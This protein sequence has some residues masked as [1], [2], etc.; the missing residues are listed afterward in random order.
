MNTTQI[1]KVFEKNKRFLG[2]FP[3]DRV[4]SLK[5]FSTEKGLI[6]NL[7]PASKPGSHWVA[8]FITPRGKGKK[9]LVEY[10]DS[11][12]FPPMVNLPRSKQQNYR[13]VFNKC[14]LQ[15]YNTTTCGQFCVYFVS[16]R[17]K[18]KS[19]AWIVSKL[20]GQPNPDAFVRKYVRDSFPHINSQVCRRVSQ[21]CRDFC[22]LP[23]CR[24]INL[25]TL[26]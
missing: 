6:V 11:Y 18:N 14:R 15:G 16:Q 3:S 12:G 5:R 13:I 7:D 9:T 10:F 25:A 21:C 20:K 8:L 17:L 26:L 19:F 23:P 24:K 2:V 4:P 22:P 1:E